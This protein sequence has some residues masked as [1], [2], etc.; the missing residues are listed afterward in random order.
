MAF[1]VLVGYTQCLVLSVA[2]T[3]CFFCR[4]LFNF[5]VSEGRRFK[6]SAHCFCGSRQEDSSAMGV[7]VSSCFKA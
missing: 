7:R 6:R 1:N 5:K 4:K 2:V 3:T